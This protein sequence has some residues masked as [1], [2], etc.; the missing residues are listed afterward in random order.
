MPSKYREERI[1][2]AAACPVCMM[3]VGTMCIGDKGATCVRAHSPRRKRWQVVR[4][5]AQLL[6][7]VPNEDI[8]AEVLQNA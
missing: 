3:P 6:H 8:V 7:G 4:D 2:A 1:V 5:A